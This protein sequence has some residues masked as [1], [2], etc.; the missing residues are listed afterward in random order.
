MLEAG[1]PLSVVATIMEWSASTTVRMSRRYG[2]IGHAAQRQ[3]MDAL[4][5][6]AFHDD[7]A[8]KWALFQKPPVR[9]LPN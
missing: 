9:Q 4:N 5:R 8:Q 2:H 6:A 3:A 7:G 1:V